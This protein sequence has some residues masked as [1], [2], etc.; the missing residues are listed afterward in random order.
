MNTR[1]LTPKISLINHLLTMRYY[2]QEKSSKNKTTSIVI[3]SPDALS[4]VLFCKQIIA[5]FKKIPSSRISV[6]CNAD[7]FRSQLELLGVEVLHVDLFRHFS[8]V[9]DVAYIV[10][11]WSLLRKTRADI[12][13]NMTTKPLI[14]GP[15]AARL[16]GVKYVINYNVGLGK[17][18][19][20]SPGLRQAVIRGTLKTLYKLSYLLSNKDWFTNKK[21]LEMLS[22]AGLVSKAKSFATNFYLDTDHYCRA[23][24]SDL[25][26]KVLRQ[27]L[28]ISEDA[29]VVS[30]VARL[31]WSKGIRE[32]TE[33]AEIIGASHPNVMFVL[34]APEE[35]GS[36]G[37]V[38]LDFIRLTCE[39][40]QCFRWI[41]FMDDPR[42]LYSISSISVL[43][44]FYPE[45][46]F[47]R[48]LT[49]PMSMSNPIVTTDNPSCSGTVDQGKNGF[50]VPVKD[51]IRLAEAIR[52]LVADQ[53]LREQFGR[54]S[55]EKALKDFDEKTIVPKA[56]KQLG[57]EPYGW[58]E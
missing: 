33:A 55:R 17:G 53:L 31:I 10:R 39:R 57:L 13:F 52:T 6:A 1:V 11:L 9:R 46:G 58:C 51:S 18:F 32:F 50:I 12:V 40:L 7:T 20:A 44:S 30:M 19:S 49:E 56:F 38:P 29:I 8:P 35:P 3:I 15:I 42:L 24:I 4:V 5:E 16:V 47:P 25:Q 37:S 22:Q 54:Y 45:G 21:D 23:A 26:A 34:L 28:D 43:P 36:D 14:Y 27:Q 41:N 48:A 2:H